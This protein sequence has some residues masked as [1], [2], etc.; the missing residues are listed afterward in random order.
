MAFA[1]GRVDDFWRGS[2]ADATFSSVRGTFL[3]SRNRTRMVENVFLIFEMI[4]LQH[5]S[6]KECLANL[7]F[8]VWFSKAL[9]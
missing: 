9:V 3:R 6:T 5:E 8:V 1:A 7:A 2:G 4:V